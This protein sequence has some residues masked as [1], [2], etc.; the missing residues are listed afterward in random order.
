MI[1]NK[2]KKI[3]LGVLLATTSLLADMS[4]YE[5]QTKSLLGI[6]G[7]YN[8]IDYQTDTSTATNNT[9]LGSLGLKI[10]SETKNFRVFLSSRYMLESGDEYDYILTY[11]GEFQY[12]LSPFDFMNLFIGVNG[13]MANIRFIPPAGGY[14]TVTS[15]YF[16]GDLGMNFFLTDSLDLELGARVMTIQ[17]KS[18]I[19]GVKYEFNDIMSVYSSIIFK[20]QMK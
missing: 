8:N 14:K 1:K 4:D 11:G 3:T 2:I 10:G 7:G 13:G 20:W 12:K 15:P 9:Q 5:F 6:E 18:T 17:D 19:D 16:G